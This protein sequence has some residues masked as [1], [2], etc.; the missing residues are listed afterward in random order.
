MPITEKADYLARVQTAVQHL[1]KCCAV[2]RETVPV[3]EMFRGETVWKGEVELFDLNRHPK[4]KRAYAWGH[5]E[6]PSDQGERFVAVREIP[7]VK[8]RTAVQTAIVAEGQ[9]A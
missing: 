5:R 9:K 2:W 8:D 4:G 1:H 3:H 6:G 7:P